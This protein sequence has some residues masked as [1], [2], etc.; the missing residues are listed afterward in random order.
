MGYVKRTAY[1][2]GKCIVRDYRAACRY[3][4]R[5]CW[6]DQTD[7]KRKRSDHA[8]KTFH[9]APPSKLA[10]LHT[11]ELGSSGRK[12]LLWLTSLVRFAVACGL[13]ARSWSRFG[14]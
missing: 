1:G 14:S 6:L 2:S 13:L 9:F 4:N 5:L 3:D 8:P 12:R 10:L 11:M 7:S